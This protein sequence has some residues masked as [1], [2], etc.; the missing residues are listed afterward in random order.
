[1]NSSELTYTLLRSDKKR[2]LEMMF[3]KYSKKLL[4][5][6]S[7]QWKME[8]DA[9]W[10][11]IYK[12]MYRVADVIN[13][14]EFVSEEKFAS[15]IFRIYINY[16]RN[17]IRDKKTSMQGAVEVELDQVTINR[18]HVEQKQTTKNLPLQI[19]QQELEKL[20][21]WQRILVLMRSQEIPYSEISKLVN[22]SEDQLK[23][24]Y[25]RIKNQLAEKISEQLK[26]IETKQHVGE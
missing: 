10:D 7:H 18:Y 21:D 8:E 9:S 25:G 24:Y 15:F 5:Y 2:G 20:E 22:R 13:E 6:S 26:S 23:V 4:A 11:L 3:D 17:Y 16:L 14:Y 1:M 19:L 12:T